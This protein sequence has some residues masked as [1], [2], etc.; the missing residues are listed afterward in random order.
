MNGGSQ[1]FESSLAMS[2]MAP[3]SM[4]RRRKDEE[5]TMVPE[6]PRLVAPSSC[7]V[8]TRY[9]GMKVIS[10]IGMNQLA[11]NRSSPRIA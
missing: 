2:S 5:S 10:S 9:D 3:L 7:E 8:P 1:V 11:S 6:R 4:K